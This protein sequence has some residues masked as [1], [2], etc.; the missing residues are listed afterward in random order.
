MDTERAT[1]DNMDGFE[2][3]RMARLLEVYRS[4]YYDWARRQAAGPAWPSNAGPS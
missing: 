2:V 1:P 4:G 3:A